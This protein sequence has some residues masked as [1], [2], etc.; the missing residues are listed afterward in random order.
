MS[1]NASMG[2]L[3]LRAGTSD[4]NGTAACGSFFKDLGGRC[5]SRLAQRQGVTAGK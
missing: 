1:I 3:G 4:L 2:N 5:S